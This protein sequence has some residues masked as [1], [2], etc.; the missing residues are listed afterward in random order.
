MRASHAYKPL[1]LKRRAWI[2]IGAVVLGGAGAATYAMAAEQT[3]P[4]QGAERRAAAVHTLK[5]QT[6]GDRKVVPRKSTATFSAVSVTWQNPDAEI[7]GKAQF[8]AR[9]AASGSWGAW[10]ALPA[11]TNDADG[12]ERERSA[13]RGGTASVPTEDVSDGVEVRVVAADGTASGLPAGMDVK[14]IDPGTGPSAAD[15]AQ[16]VAYSEDT[17]APTPTVTATDSGTPS[18]P[19]PT[20]PTF[21]SP[22]ET[23]PTAP[24]STVVKPDI[25]PQSVWGPGLSHDGTPTYD[26]DIKAAVVHHTGV[27]ADNQVPCAKSAER[28]RQIQQD[29]VSK[30]YYDLGY[31]FVVD[32]CGQIFEGR[33]GGM[34]L[35]VHG[36]HDYGFNTDTVGIS[37]IGN[38][39]SAKPTKAALDAIARVAAW[40]FGQYGIVATGNVTLTS[41]G[42]L[43]VDGNKVAKGTTITLPRVFGHKDTNATLCPGANLYPKLSRIRTLAATPGISHAL[44][45]QNVAGDATPDIV[46]GVP[47]GT[48]GGQV[49]VVPGA[50]A[51][52]S[53]TGKKVV[54]QAG[55]VPGAA[56]SGDEFGASTA[57]GD[58]N[59]D[60]YTDLV[61]G[62]PGEDDTSGHTDRGAATVVYGPDFTGGLGINMDASYDLTGAR[63]GSAVAVGDFNADGT[64]DVFAASTGL[65]GTWMARYGDG[66]DTDSTI[67]G[68][69][70]NLSNA[71]AAAGDFNLDGYADVALNYRDDTGVGRVTWYKGGSGGLRKAATLST[72]GG[73]SI[74]AGDINGDG[75]DDIAIG[76][77]YV[78]ESGAAAGGQVT[79][80][81]GVAGTGLTAT[82]A[83]S[84]SQ[85][86]SGVPGAGESGDAMGWSVTVGDYDLDGYA[87]ILTGAPNEDIT[88]TTNQANAGTS[89]LL[90]GTS[91][92]PTGTGSLAITQDTDGVPGATETNDNLGTAVALGDFS[93][94]GRADLVIGTAG[95]DA[96]NGTLM[97]VPSNS[98]GPGLTS[99]KTFNNTTLGTPAGARL[100]TNLAP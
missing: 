63:F 62:Q 33:T 11:E 13:I 53:A 7:D 93:G 98:S 70:G 96:G 99:T 77:P 59:G 66:W 71:D 35:P 56:E 76:Q 50:A 12:A 54:S 60:G 46:T 84:I 89:L 29:H 52:P 83:K 88:R 64:A 36:A 47:K 30:G 49:V 31:N 9:D 78:A 17:P 42:D 21:P 48:G 81:K 85:D 87:D 86:T 90:K 67:T 5:M 1:S 97:Y 41:N 44:V 92:G 3:G 20:V 73:R 75:V 37:Y 100:G 80:V 95:E 15:L 55:D 82:G 4:A 65:G 45:S 2:T 79:F 25:I 27:D 8:R 51:G 16:P 68:T 94:F 74:A 32:R 43:D 72:K 22:T 39:E 57:T 91:S 6:K 24:P 26:T 58:I 34:D 18:P 38:F 69:E 28:L 23:V 14:L 10:T 19:D 61:V 40:K